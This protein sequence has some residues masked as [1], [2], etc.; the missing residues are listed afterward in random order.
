MKRAV[1][2]NGRTYTL[3][4]MQIL[5]G[6]RGTVA[7]CRELPDLLELGDNPN[8]ALHRATEVVERCASRDT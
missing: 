4:A 7:I 8:D 6:P 3:S 5:P 1:V 2:R